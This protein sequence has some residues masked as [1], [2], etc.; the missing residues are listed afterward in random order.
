MFAKCCPGFG[1]GALAILA[2]MGCVGCQSGVEER[3]NN[4][5]K[6]SGQKKL[7]V[8][9]LAGRVTIDGQPP[10]S[11]VKG[12][13]TLML[14]LYDV[15]KPNLRPDARPRVAVQP[16]G[17][18]QFTTYGAGDGAAA[19]TY[20]VV[21]A[22]LTDRKKQG[23]V[24]PDGLKNLYNDPEKNETIPEFKID[25]KATGKTDYHFDLKVAGNENPTPGSKALTSI[26]D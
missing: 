6:S 20:V 26:S 1:M 3:V 18:F 9:P 22:L 4:E 19:G 25:H 16:D 13:S 15:A 23:L 17:S 2:A 11:L 24:G 10:G 5:L 12:R 14:V 21:F 8:F 7:D